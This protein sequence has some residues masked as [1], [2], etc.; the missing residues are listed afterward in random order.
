MLFLCLEANAEMVPKYQ[1]ATACFSDLN[2][3]KLILIAVKP[4]KLFF[5]IRHYFQKSKFRCPCLKLLRLTILTPSLS[6]YS[7]IL[8]HKDELAKPGN[9]LTKR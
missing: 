6:R 2:V 4:P 9:F 5:K 1:L 8:Y 7:Y 3:S